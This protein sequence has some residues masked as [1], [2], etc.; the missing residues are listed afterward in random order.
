MFKVTR[1]RVSIPEA[2]LVRFPHAFVVRT[3]LE[4][5]ISVELTRRVCK[6]YTVRI[7]DEGGV[8]LM[9]RRFSMFKAVRQL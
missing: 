6:V 1:P 8:G 5:G 9:E 7:E 4:A 2:K 3:E